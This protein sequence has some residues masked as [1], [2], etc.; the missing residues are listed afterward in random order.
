MITAEKQA[1]VQ[2]NFAAL[3]LDGYLTPDTMRGELAEEYRLLKRP[4]LTTANGLNDPTLRYGNPILITSALPGE[5]KT[6]TAFNLAM[7]IALEL[8]KTV[9]LVDSDITRHSLTGLAGLNDTLGLTDVLL[10]EHLD[11]A[12]VILSSNVPKLKLIPAGRTHRDATELLASKRMQTMV[13]E[14]SERYNDRIVL[15][16]APPLLT[17]SQAIVLTNLMGKILVVVEEGKTPQHI[18]QEAVSLL[19][20]NKAIGMVLNRCVHLFTRNYYYS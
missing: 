17:T 3:A 2:I 14:L 12:D 19:G 10:D 13:R 9:L 8:D 20:K 18:I 1:A 7:S 4:L 16:D 5:G 6:F 11:L 15:F